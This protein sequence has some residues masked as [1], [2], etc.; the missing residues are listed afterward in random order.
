[1]CE[2]RSRILVCSLR[3]APWVWVWKNS[4][5]RKA[6]FPIVWPLKSKRIVCAKVDS[7]NR[8]KFKPLVCIPGIL[9]L[10]AFSVAS[11]HSKQIQQCFSFS[12]GC[13]LFQNKYHQI[14][15][16]TSL[17]MA[18]WHVKCTHLWRVPS[19]QKEGTYL[20]S[21]WS[22]YVYVHAALTFL[23]EDSFEC[24]PMLRGWLI[25]QIQEN[26]CR[27]W[28]RHVTEVAL[29]LCMTSRDIPLC[30]IA[31]FFVYFSTAQLPTIPGQADTPSSRS[32]PFRFYFLI[33]TSWQPH[34]ASKMWE[35]VTYDNFDKE[36]DLWA[37]LCP[38]DVSN[39]PEAEELAGMGIARSSS[40]FQI[41]TLTPYNSEE[42]LSSKVV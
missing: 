18:H 4:K 32:A 27:S 15:V 23:N 38:I 14:P 37:S 39:K 7:S 42:P 19:C 30:H 20:P 9:V 8:L 36:V 35:H 16:D 21:T 31:L 41:L 13:V 3:L 12:G 2:R 10:L 25:P 33:L 22:L 5:N 40:S 17:L 34:S 24:K 28:C 29:S 11:F 6:N 26:S 1:M